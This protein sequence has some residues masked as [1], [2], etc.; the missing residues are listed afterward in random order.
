LLHQYTIIPAQKRKKPIFFAK[1]GKVG[2]K[3]VK[4]KGSWDSWMRL[5]DTP[6][7]ASFLPF[8]RQIK[9]RLVA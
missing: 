3:V 2:V 6:D 9:E 5:S 8:I 1:C 4:Y 7:Y